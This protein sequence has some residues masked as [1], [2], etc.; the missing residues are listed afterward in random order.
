MNFW[1]ITFAGGRKVGTLQAETREQ[2]LTRARGLHSHPIDAQKLPYPA[3]PYLE[4]IEC[5]AFCR[6]PHSCAGRGTCPN[7]P[8]CAS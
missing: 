5:P 8:S 4:R 7:S 2:A 3:S 6:T 1:W